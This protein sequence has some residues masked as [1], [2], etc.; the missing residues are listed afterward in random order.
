MKK[1]F[2]Y[3]TTRGMQIAFSGFI[4][5]LIGVVAGFL[6]FYINKEWLSMAGLGATAVGVFIGFV[7]V[8]YGWARDAK[9]AV[10]RSIRASKELSSKLFARWRS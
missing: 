2:F 1:D 7:G 4:L 5:A 3:G 9:P 6:G 8:A 10:K